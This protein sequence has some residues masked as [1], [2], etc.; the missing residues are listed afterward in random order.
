MTKYEPLEE[1][2]QSGNRVKMKEGVIEG[3]IINIL[4][5]GKYYVEWDDG[6]Y[7]VVH[8]KDIERVE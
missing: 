2:M 5:L 4:W 6:C 1:P 8:L 3:T 7:T